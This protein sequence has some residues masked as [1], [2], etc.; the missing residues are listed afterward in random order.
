MREYVR[1]SRNKMLHRQICSLFDMLEMI[2]TTIFCAVLL[3]AYV[4]SMATVQGDSMMPTLYDEDRLLVFQLYGSP[5]NG[6][7][8]IINAQEATLVA[9]DGSLYTQQGLG[10]MIVKRVVAVGGQTLDIDFD[11]GVVYLDQQPLDEEYINM[12]TTTP[13][14]GGAFSYPMTIPEGYVFVMGDNRDVSKDSRYPDVG[15]IPESTIIGKV[16]LRT[17]PWEAFGLI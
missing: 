6:D 1:F 15:L 7:V 10:K 17:E 4:F 5:K 3:F 16:I 13:L 14:F 11:E 2:V 8:I 12:P 9:E